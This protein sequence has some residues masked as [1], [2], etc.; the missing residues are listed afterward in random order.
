MQTNL[1]GRVA[2]V[3]GASRGIGQATAELLVASGAR[4]V[5]TGRKPDAL[6]EAAGAIEAQTTA[7]E[8]AWVAANAGDPEAPATIIATVMERFGGVDIV[9][10]NAATNPYFGPALDIDDARWQKTFDVNLKG[11][12]ALVREAWRAS[13]STQ[14]GAVVNVASVGGLSVEPGIGVYNVTKAA[15]MHLTRTLAAELG[16]MVRVN[17]VAPGLVRTDMARGLWE[18]HGEAFARR[19][20]LRRLGEPED[21][22]RAIVF[23]VSD[24]SSWMTGA[25]LVIDGGAVMRG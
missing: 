19:L 22:P 1:D 17:A 21:I 13:M 5:L 4:V 23:L 8:V 20:P 2:V 7:A 6:E 12:H 25:T 16:P 15:L 9:V 14:G 24:L 11:A 3:T 10:N 18:E